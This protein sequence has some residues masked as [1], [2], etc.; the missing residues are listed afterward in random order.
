MT[1]SKK[2]NKNR[3]QAKIQKKED[4][5]LFF[6]LIVIIIGILIGYSFYNNYSNEDGS[7]D[8][9]NT[10]LI[11]ENPPGGSQENEDGSTDDPPDNPPEN[12]APDFTITDLDGNKVTLSTFRGK[13]VVLD[14]MATWC[15]PCKEEMK[16]LNEIHDKYDSA[17]VVIMSIGI[18]TSESEKQLSDFKNEFGGD[19]IFAMDTNNIGDKYT[20]SNI[21]TMVIVDKDGQI[22]LRDEGVIKSDKLSEEIDKVL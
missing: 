1:K 15:P 22:S 7:N 13:V 6:I 12:P 16:H 4:I 18:D 10:G 17:R 5:T 8:N 20:V 2:S 11:D 19:W 3:D 9:T 14:L 21:P